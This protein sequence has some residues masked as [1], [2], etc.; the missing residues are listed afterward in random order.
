[1]FALLTK[2]TVTI[3]KVV[4]HVRE[5]A[6]ERP[7]LSGGK[8]TSKKTIARG[9]AVGYRLMYFLGSVLAIYLK[10]S[11]GE[12]YFLYLSVCNDV[13]PTTIT[14]F[15]DN[16]GVSLVGFYKYNYPLYPTRQEIAIITRPLTF[17]R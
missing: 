16:E 14:M 7:G 3:A 4:Q 12:M 6:R 10:V 11:V 5:H 2:A 17:Q 1:M 15:N 13:S 9:A 8:T